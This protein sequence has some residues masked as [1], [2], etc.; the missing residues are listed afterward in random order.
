MVS[1]L[2]ITICTGIT[3][4]S[5][6]DNNIL[7]SNHDTYTGTKL[8]TRKASSLRADGLPIF[9]RTFLGNSASVVNLTNNSILIPDHYFVTGEKLVYSYEN[10]LQ[11]T[12]AWYSNSI[13]RGC[14]N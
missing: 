3:S 4:I 6:L 14:F 9:E 2:R 1:V 11:N 5:D 13:D 12:N 8:D 10:S 7:F